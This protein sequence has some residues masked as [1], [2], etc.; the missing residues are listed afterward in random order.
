MAIDIGSGATDRGTTQAAGYTFIDI[1]NPSL[2]KGKITSIEL[3]FATDASGV[4]V[5]TMYGS[6]T[7]WTPRD[8]EIIGSVTS[9]S[10]QTFTVDLDVHV[11]D[12]I[13]VYWS[14]GTLEEDSSGGVAVYYKS[15][16]QFSAGTQT[17][18]YAGGFSISIYGTGDYATGYAYDISEGNMI[19][20][21]GTFNSTV[22]CVIPSTILSNTGKTQARIH[23]YSS[24]VEAL[25][26]D[27]SAI[28]M[29]AA[30][31]DAY[32]YDGS[33]TQVYWDDG[34]AG[35]AISANDSAI[36]DWT[37]FEVESGKNLII[38]FMCTND[39]AK[40]GVLSTSIS[41]GRSYYK[42]GDDV[43]TKDAT[44]YTAGSVGFIWAS[45][46]VEVQGGIAGVKTINGIAAEDV[47][48]V[49]G[50]AVADIKSIQGL[51]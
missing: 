9:G 49:N 38:A 29:A 19:N 14:S 43:L 50:V 24:T 13:A 20:G 26:I 6:G 35:K 8:S 16:D 46:A 32:D 3:W 47:K 44:G 45:L 23:L 15:G 42:T 11:G 51:T 27:K 12:V 30:S 17:Y 28:G 33:Q 31:G 36:S 21:G 25:T 1:A 5:G 7:S 4:K 39:A 18:T 2:G 40:D 34:N 10:K 48:T 37:T 22:R 41:G